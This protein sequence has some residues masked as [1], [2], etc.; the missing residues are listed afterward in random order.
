M[1]DS[2]RQIKLMHDAATATG[3]TSLT[4]R[5]R[6]AIVLTWGENIGFIALSV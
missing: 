2:D 5:K 1:T 4:K 6:G 3:E